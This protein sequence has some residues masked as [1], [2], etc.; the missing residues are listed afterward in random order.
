MRPTGVN[1]YLG[2]GGLGL[3]GGEAGLGLGGGGHGDGLGDS[4]NKGEVAYN[5]S[6]M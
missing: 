6:D 1:L 2:L 3:G 5:K 4:E